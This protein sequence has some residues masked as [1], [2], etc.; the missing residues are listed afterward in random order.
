MS[1][2]V[3][4]WIVGIAFALVVLPPGRCWGRYLLHLR[5]GFSKRLRINKNANEGATAKKAPASFLEPLVNESAWQ[6]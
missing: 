1:M 3:N 6:H 5:S 2:F 4:S